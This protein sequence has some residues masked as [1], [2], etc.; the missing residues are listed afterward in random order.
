MLA[1][2]TPHPAV[3]IHSPRPTLFPL[4]GGAHPPLIVCLFIPL[5]LAPHSHSLSSCPFSLL[6]FP[7]FFLLSL[8]LPFPPLPTLFLH[9]FSPFRFQPCC[10]TPWQLL[11]FILY[12]F[13]FLSVNRL[14]PSAGAV[15]LYRIF[16]GFPFFKKEG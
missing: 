11:Q 14:P 10:W 1:Y 15:P 6:P 4:E 5:L 13:S 2:W 12:L 3:D 9:S 16:H 8:L 7:P